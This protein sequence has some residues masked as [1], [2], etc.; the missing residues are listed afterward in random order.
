VKGRSNRLVQNVN[1]GP[2]GKLR[3]LYPERTVVLR[4]ILADCPAL[5][6]HRPALD[7]PAVPAAGLAGAGFAGRGAVAAGGS[8]VPGVTFS[9]RVPSLPVTCER[10]TARHP[11][12]EGDP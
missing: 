9:L 8:V 2:F 6:G 3:S 1:H 10:P 5:A 7:E 4:P 12:D 11:P